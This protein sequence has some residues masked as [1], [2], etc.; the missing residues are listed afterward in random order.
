[1][2]PERLSATDSA[3]LLDRAPLLIWRSGANAHRDYFNDSWLRFTGRSREEELGEGWMQGVHPDDLQR[4][5]DLF[6]DPLRGLAPFEVEYRLR[7]HDGL[8]RWVLERGVPIHEED[9]IRGFVGACL[10]IHDRRRGE[11]SREAALRMIAHELRTPLQAVKMRAEVMR[12][13]AAGGEVCTPDM[14]DRL[15]VQID[16][17]GRLIS[18]LSADGRSARAL[19]SQ[20]PAGSRGTAAPSGRPALRRAARVAR[21]GPPSTDVSR[22]RA[23]R[24]RRREPQSRA[25]LPRVARQRVQVLAPWRKRRGRASG[26]RR[27]P[28]RHDPGRG[29]RDSGGGP[30]VGRPA[31]LSSRQRP[32]ASLFG[33][34]PRARRRPGTSSSGTAA[35]SPSRASWIA[36]RQITVTLPR[37]VAELA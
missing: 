6:L 7:R 13:A 12:R 4:R 17:L 2:L 27:A 31:I 15:D 25:G 16:R 18:D 24:R 14:F 1:M 29:G 22:P 26:R 5:T 28:P 9:A 23:R 37:S 19:A 11:E 10:D 34:G 20:G 21:T 35:V 8:Y 3:T 33:P 30:E 36:G 32:P